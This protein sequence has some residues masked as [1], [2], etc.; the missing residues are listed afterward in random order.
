MSNGLF[1]WA[2]T[3]SPLH[4]GIGQTLGKVDLPI[5]RECHTTYPC[6]YAT[7]L[8]G[9]FRSFCEQKANENP[10]PITQDD[11]NKIFG[12]EHDP[13]SAGSA[14]FTDLK[15]LLFPVRASKDAFKWVTSPWV[16][17]RFKRDY[18]LALNK[19]F[20]EDFLRKVN[21]VNQYHPDKHIILEDFVFY[22]QGTPD[23]VLFDFGDIKIR[24]KDVYVVDENIFKYLVNNATQVIARNVLSKEKTSDNL[25][26]EEALP[27]DTVL[28]S[29]I[30]PSV[31]NNDELSKL[32]SP[33][34]LDK[35]VVQIGG[36]ETVGYG[37]TKI[38]FA[39]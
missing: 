11:I 32:K 33:D 16:I 10:P 23:D 24:K 6:V 2:Y 17:D 30:L 34:L 35:K 26:Y 14:I 13:T 39:S 21:T 19:D 1:F 3:Y 31:T 20:D 38:I 4:A 5:E 8:K 7:G 12:Q 29:F 28:Y 15:I 25:W 37:L 9:A 22:L 27:A 36:N 18:K